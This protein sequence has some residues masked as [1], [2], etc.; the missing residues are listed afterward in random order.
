MMLMRAIQAVREKYGMDLP[1]FVTMDSNS[2]PYSVVYDYYRYLWHS[3]GY[4][5]NRNRYVHLRS[6][7]EDYYFGEEP[8]FTNYSYDFIGCLDY[9]FYDP[10]TVEKEGVRELLRNSDLNNVLALPSTVCPSDHIPLQ[11]EALLLDESRDCPEPA[12]NGT[13]RPIIT[14]PFFQCVYTF[15]VCFYTSL[16]I[17]L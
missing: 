7:Y 3:L 13:F 5:M 12:K 11:M 16:W 9:I 17:L 1:L 6:A 4:L 8:L 2:Q 14:Q 15:V 10:R